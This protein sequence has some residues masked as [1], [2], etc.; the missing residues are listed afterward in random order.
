MA[1]FVVGR[2]AQ[3]PPGKRHV[4]TV[5]NRPI[6]IFNLKGELFAM[7]NRCPHQGAELSAGMVT[8]IAEADEPGPVRCSRQGE[9]VRCP[10]HGWEFDIRTGQAW[11]EP[12]R[13]AVKQFQVSVEPGSALVQ[14]P[15][16]AETFSITV[17]DDYVVVEV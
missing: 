16:K 1:K 17:E 4:V 11:C 10:W 9:F 13:I 3:I 12:Q 7:L 8:G 5:K 2:L 14:G 6:V 15:Y